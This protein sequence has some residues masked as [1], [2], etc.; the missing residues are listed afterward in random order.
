MRTDSIG[1]FWQ[2]LPAERGKNKIA[3][4]MPEIPHTGWTAPREF[5]RLDNV[6]WLSFDVETKDPNL[7]THGPG[8]ARGD[9]HIIGFSVG[10]PGYNR[11]FPIRHE[12]KPE[13]NLPA[14][15][16]LN[17]LRD[18]ARAHGNRPVMGANLLYDLGWASEENITFA[19]PAYDIQF[20]EALLSEQGLTNLDHLGMKYLQEGKTSNTLYQWCADYYGG[21]PNGDQRKNLWR[22]PPSLVGPY[23][24][25]D[26][27]L[28][29]R[30]LVKQWEALHREGLLGVWEMETALIPLLIAMRRVGV[31]VD[32]NRAGEVMDI[33]T[34]Q[35]KELEKRLRDLAGF[36]VN[37][38]AGE[39]MKKAFQKLNIPIPTKKGKPCFDKDHLARVEHPLVDL[40]G[41]IKKRTKA[42]DT[43]VKS[44][45]IDKH[46]KG[47]VHCQFHPLR[48]DDGGTR[49]GRFASS[50]PNYQNVISRDEELTPLIRSCFIPDAGHAR[51]R[52]FDYSQIE[53][54]FNA[55]YAVGR[56]SDELR[57]K[58]NA[59]PDT[60]YHVETQRLVER[61]VGVEIP[62]KP[63]KNL[64]FGLTF[65]MGETKMVAGLVT[66]LSRMGKG[67]AFDGQSLFQAYHEAL[68]FSRETL[69]HYANQATSVGYVQTILGRRSRFDLWEPREFS[70]G[71]ERKPALP[72]EM[73][74]RFYGDIKRAYSHK[75][76]NR[77]LQG[78]A[79]DLIK[80][81]MVR[82]WKEG[83]YSYIG[84]PRLTVHDELDHSDAGGQEKAWEYYH[85]EVLEKSLKLR[86]P[87]IADL[88]MGS[89][90]GNCT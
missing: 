78:S 70:R 62:R 90:W 69:N 19:G 80:T 9:G 89:N 23:A 61:F 44:Y 10:A 26:T 49:S 47:K 71:G 6:P 31:S 48:G 30:I 54:R 58:Y 53:Y 13:E 86:I 22:T 12:V 17:W 60:D 51:W 83:L 72:Y 4:V 55:H 21:K 29:P 87:V 85:H 76:L 81:A 79:A 24:E 50:D 3:R 28:P 74:L 52:R 43:F 64:N 32:I 18:T 14:E 38:N 33:L 5:P 1:L 8:W 65:G 7:L 2:D 63:I 77:V 88:E 35:I 41:E 73:A 11:Y 57:A 66:E 25:G 15:H 27:A 34:V 56:G 59:D 40:V 20:A 82:A 42:R 67:F 45:I 37:P 36:E 46:V 39:S 84:V 16:C 75:A 68:P